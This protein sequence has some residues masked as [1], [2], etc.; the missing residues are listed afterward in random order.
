VCLQYVVWKITVWC[1][2]ILETKST[3]QKQIK[4]I[5]YKT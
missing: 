3:K 1:H 4:Y 2:Y 5:S